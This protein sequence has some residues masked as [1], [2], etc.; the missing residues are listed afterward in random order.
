MDVKGFSWVGVGVEDFGAAVAFFTDVLGLRCLSADDRGVAILQVSEGQLL[1]IFGPGTKGHAL[2]SAPVAAF[3]VVDV[4]AA[5]DELL[6]KGVEVIGETGS[7]N[8]FEWAYFPGP[9]GHIFSIKK[10][11]PAAWVQNA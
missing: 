11:P 9:A 1:E 5:R 8:G 3:E 2:T 7:W 10:T 6:A 4:A